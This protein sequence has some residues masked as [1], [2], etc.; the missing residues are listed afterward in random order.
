MSES[1]GIVPE[2]AE[3]IL[4]PYRST[5]RPLT[6]LYMDVF[7]PAH[8]GPWPALLHFH[9]WHQDLVHARPRARLLASRGFCVLNLNLRGRCGTVGQPDANGWELRDACDALAAAR[10]QFPQLC[11]E[12]LAPRAFGASGGGG[13]VYA[14]IGKCPDLVASAVVW[15]GISDYARWFETD[16]KGDY[17]DEMAV[18]IAPS[19][20]VNAE[21]YRSRAGLTVAPNRICPLK[22]IHGRGDDCVPIE[23]AWAYRDAQ[24]PGGDG[25]VWAFSEL[26]GVG[27]A[28]PDDPYLDE[29]CEFLLRHYQPLYIPQLGK[30][31]VAG[32]LK[33]H[34]FEVL[35]EHLDRVGQVDVDLRRRRMLLECPRSGAAQVRLAGPIKDAEITEPKRGQRILSLRSESGWTVLDLHTHGEP[36]ALR[37]KV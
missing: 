19:P 10:A 28:I 12:S 21:A 37:W 15:C 36:F 14:L 7:A 4:T 33:T 11:S 31:V 17:R 29:S 23:Q 6:T 5:E 34:Y 3:H 16:K 27:H 18:W 1:R 9:G 25:P 8:G 30:W 22:V 24:A 13:N 2:L 20:E 32:F 26:P 35:W